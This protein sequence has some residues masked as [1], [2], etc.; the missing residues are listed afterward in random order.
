MIVSMKN[1]V[2]KNLIQWE[3]VVILYFNLILLKTMIFNIQNLSP[4]PFFTVGTWNFTYI[5]FELY[6]RAQ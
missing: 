4:P 6:V 3:I 5:I 2:S 1:L